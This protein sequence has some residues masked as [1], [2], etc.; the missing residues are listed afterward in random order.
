[1]AWEGPF[2]FGPQIL[3]HLIRQLIQEERDH[4]A[5]AGRTDVAGETVELGLR[6]GGSITAASCNA[7]AICSIRF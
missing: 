5:G 3:P 4:L 1:M 6:H 7:F 2:L